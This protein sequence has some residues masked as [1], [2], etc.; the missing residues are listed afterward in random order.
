[1]EVYVVWKQQQFEMQQSTPRWLAMLYGTQFLFQ[2]N[3]LLEG[4]AG[5]AMYVTVVSVCV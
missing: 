1:M 5:S 3:R 4:N 2:T